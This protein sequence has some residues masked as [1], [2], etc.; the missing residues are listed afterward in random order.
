MG[1]IIGYF[2]HYKQDSLGAAFF[3]RYS[4]YSDFLFGSVL[5]TFAANSRPVEQMFHQ[6]FAVFAG[7]NATELSLLHIFDLFTRIFIFIYKKCFS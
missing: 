2:L 6:T 3:I 7:L 5:Q 1:D 4:K